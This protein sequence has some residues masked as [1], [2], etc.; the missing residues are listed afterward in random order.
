LCLGKPQNRLSAP[1]CTTVGAGKFAEFELDAENAA[2]F[3]NYT[4]NL[5]DDGFHGLLTVSSIQ[6]P[7]LRQ[8]SE[9]TCQPSVFAQ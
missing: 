5:E 4:F 7:V 6:R 3:P 2:E 1:S 9:K 8:V